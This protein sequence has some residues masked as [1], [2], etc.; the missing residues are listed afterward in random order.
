MR[1]EKQQTEFEKFDATVGK[2]LSVTRKEL[3][4]RE[5]E[6]K[7]RRNRKKRAKT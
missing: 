6:W 2:M 7:K 3:Q 4:R 5:L 1:T